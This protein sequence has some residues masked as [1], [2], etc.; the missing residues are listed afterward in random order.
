MLSHTKTWIID[1][2]SALQPY[3]SLCSSGPWDDFVARQTSFS[4]SLILFCVY[5]LWGDFPY[6]YHS[7]SDVWKEAESMLAL[8]FTLLLT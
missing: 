1:S 3:L 7:S 6:R 8:L 4:L 5:L 2:V